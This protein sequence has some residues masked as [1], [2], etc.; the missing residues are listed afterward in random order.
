MT[1]PKVSVDQYFV[2][3]CSV[4]RS[5][6]SRDTLKIKGMGTF[7][8][9]GTRTGRRAADLLAQSQSTGVTQACTVGRVAESD[10]FYNGSCACVARHGRQRQRQRPYRRRIHVLP[11]S[12]MIGEA[13]GAATARISK[14]PCQQ[15]R[16][17]RTARCTRQTASA[18]GSG[19]PSVSNPVARSR[20]FLLEG[21]CFVDDASNTRHTLLKA[22]R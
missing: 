4:P 21:S 22:S 10:R 19:G 17:R 8:E 2:A 1:N 12:R 15:Q 16:H 14:N 18:G 13:C 6:G 7:P 11:C 20:L 5:S 3:V 9:T